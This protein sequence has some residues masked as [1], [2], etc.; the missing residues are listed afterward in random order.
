MSMTT[1]KEENKVNNWIRKYPSYFV[2]LSSLESSEKRVLFEGLPKSDL[3]D[4][5]SV[6]IFLAIN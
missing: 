5:M 1:A 2:C 3:T 6:R 4:C